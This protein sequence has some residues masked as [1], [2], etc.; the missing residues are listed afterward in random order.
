MT[1]Q[2]LYD[3]TGRA[4][5]LTQRQKTLPHGMIVN[6]AYRLSTARGRRGRRIN[7]A[8]FKAQ[9]LYHCGTGLTVIKTIDPCSNM[10]RYPGY[11]EAVKTTRLTPAR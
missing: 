5:T 11:T 1:D 6:V 2:P 3:H 10:R 9:V 8:S 7:A 4:Y